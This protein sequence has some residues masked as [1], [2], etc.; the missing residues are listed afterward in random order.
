MAQAKTSGDRNDTASEE[1]RTCALLEVLEAIG[2]HWTLPELI[3]EV[4]ERLTSVVGCESVLLMLHEPERD[5]LRL[6]LLGGQPTGLTGA[7]A[8]HDLRDSVLAEIM[9]SQKPLLIPSTRAESDECRT[10]DLLACNGLLS[11]WYFPLSTPRRKLGLLGFCG[12]REGTPSASD[13]DLLQRVTNQL[14]L[15]VE[16]AVNHE[17]FTSERDRLKLLLD[18]NAAVVSHLDPKTLIQAIADSLKRIVR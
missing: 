8:E 5:V 1:D 12:S 15:A 18:L 4:A 9:A 11:V 3:H 17:S 2:S 16:N 14:A 7:E 10:M 6:H 13:Q